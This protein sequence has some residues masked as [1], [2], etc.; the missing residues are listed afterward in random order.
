MSA[1]ASPEVG[2]LDRAL[3]VDQHGIGHH[4]APF[5]ISLTAKSQARAVR[6]M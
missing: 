2:E 6:A 3:S 5:F 1:T 4:S